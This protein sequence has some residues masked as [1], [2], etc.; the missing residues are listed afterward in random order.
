MQYKRFG[1][2]YVLRLEMGDEIIESL[3]TL[4]EKEEIRGGF[5]YGLGA[6]K[7]VSLGYFDVEEKKYKEESFKQEFELASLVGDVSL[8]DEKIIIHAHATLADQDFKAFAGHLSRAEVTATV[9]IF[10]RPTG[11]VLNRKHDP[12]I[13]LNFLDLGE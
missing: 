11:G 2:A 9:E 6:V 1:A 12:S 3:R 10:L 7:S 4:A 13:G 8:L 5:F